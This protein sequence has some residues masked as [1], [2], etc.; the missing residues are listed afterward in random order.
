M[1]SDIST[2]LEDLPALS[3]EERIT[4][5]QDFAQLFSNALKHGEE[6]VALATQT[7]ELVDKHIRKLDSDLTR[8]EER[9]LTMPPR[10]TH[11]WGPGTTAMSVDK[12]SD[13]AVKSDNPG[14]LALITKYKHISKLVNF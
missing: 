6:K 14:K 8:F 4:R 13:I 7:Y 11:A 5:L 3:R 12:D 1:Q 2:Y 9:Q 10:I